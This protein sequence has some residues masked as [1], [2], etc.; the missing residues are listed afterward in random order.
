MSKKQAKNWLRLYDH[1][2]D[3][4]CENI[5]SKCIERSDNLGWVLW[6]GDN[7]TGIDYCPF[8]GR[9]LEEGG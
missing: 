1:H 6:C 7:Y 8:C 3:H 2:P 5:L 9:K 4:I